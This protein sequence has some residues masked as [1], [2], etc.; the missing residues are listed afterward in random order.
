M[1]A[2]ADC[3]VEPDHVVLERHG[4]LKRGIAFS[5]SLIPN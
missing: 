5:L 4:D 3:E 1:I 2:A